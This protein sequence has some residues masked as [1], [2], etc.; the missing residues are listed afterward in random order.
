MNKI[1]NIVWS[2]TLGQWCVVSELCKSPKNRRKGI[3][4]TIITMLSFCLV[5]TSAIAANAAADKEIKEDNSQAA[6]P[7]SLVWGMRAQSSGGSIAIGSDATADA[8]IPA[9]AS[10]AIA[11]GRAAKSTGA[12]S[13]TVGSRAIASGNYGVAVG[14][15]AKAIGGYSYAAGFGANA[16]GVDSF[17]LG[18]WSQAK[19]DYSVALGKGN[20]ALGHGSV[21]IGGISTLYKTLVNNSYGIAIGAESKVYGDESIAIGRKSNINSAANKAVIVGSQ[22]SV[23][24]DSS[25]SIVIGSEAVIGD[26][27]QYAMA[28]GNSAKANGIDSIAIGHNTHV[29]VKDGIALG[30]DSKVHS[31]SVSVG[32]NNIIT[33]QDILVLGK[34][35]T[36]N[37]DNSVYLGTSS[38]AS[39]VVT[40][41]TGGSQSAVN[42]TQVDTL[43]FGQYAG[44]QA[45][46]AVTVGAVGNERRIQNVAAGLV[47]EK[48]TDAINGSQLFATQNRLSTF[49]NGTVE[50]LG[51]NASINQDGTLKKPVYSII[52]GAPA[53]GV[54]TDVHTVGDAL[55]NLNAA[56][57]SPLY[58]SSDSG[59][60]FSRKLGS[61]IKVV[62]G[63]VDE[64]LLTTNNIG[65]VSNGIDTLSIRLAQE[66][67]GLKKA[68]F[69]NGANKTVI[70]GNGLTLSNDNGK[71]ISLTD[72]EFNNGDNKI[73]HI[74]SGLDGQLLKD[75]TGD[76]LTNAANISDLKNA[77]NDVT[78]GLTNAG[79][80]LSADDGKS[81]QKALGNNITISGDKN[82]TTS[83]TKDGKLALNLN[84]DL[85]LDDGSITI[86]DTSVN[87]KGLIIAG[88]P[89][90]TNQGIDAGGKIIS[91]LADA[92]ND[93][94]AVNLGQ[95]NEKIQNVTNAS[96]WSLT[97]ES[98]TIKHEVSNQTVSVNHGLNTKVSTV[99]K[100]AL[101]N[102]SYQIDVM[103]IPMNYIDS[104]GNEL[105]NIG[106][107]F[108]TQEVNPDT[109]ETVLTKA[110]PAKVKISNDK[111]MQLTNVANGRVTSESTDAINGSQLSAAL[112][113]V[114]GSNI[115]YN[116]GKPTLKPDTFSDLST[117][118]GGDIATDGSQ[119]KQP[120]DIVAAV[121][122][123]NKE[124][125]KYFKANSNGVAAKAEGKNSTAAGAGSVAS[126]PESVAVGHN[127]VVMSSAPVGSVS[128]GSGSKAEQAHT[129]N[130]SVDN[131]IVAGKKGKDTAVVSFG[132]EGNERQLQHVAPGVLSETSTDAVNGSQLHAVSQKQSN[133]SKAIANLGNRFNQLD[134][135]VS[136]LNRDIRGV[137][138]SAAAM[139]S[140]PQAYLPGKSLMGLGVGG[141]GGESAIAIGVSTI[142][143]NGKV[144]MKLNAGNNSRGDYSVGAG[145]GFQW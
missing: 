15:S 141:Y 8:S 85:D 61:E 9:T 124:G 118:S 122:T 131:T 62:G 52:N 98:D 11:I 74:A 102:Y 38:T 121:N 12:G 103:G 136:E 115:T 10:D 73:T 3:K 114:G 30:K 144:I 7:N 26:S 143:D 50:A 133:N 60:G 126:A 116:N 54:M 83:V 18:S 67:I 132:S 28:L 19:G 105:V 64:G 100:D 45:N 46:G 55:T 75:A 119:F 58:F 24:K 94:D 13:L 101:G 140:I 138:A 89:S 86:G 53:D 49:V 97:T 65:V 44:A 81:V 32:N 56:V 22:S 59:A 130:Y 137:G 39:D 77:I 72:T 113:I 93:D 125:T 91:G 31:A 110:I 106:G 76:T 51:G 41:T 78:N 108:Y 82:I 84:K 63:N 139:S 117:A 68:E 111:P 27:S 25:G 145:V 17:A 42:N 142:S 21:A 71:I 5:S 48:S 96:T 29:L 57:G 34:N 43:V 40:D 70:D 127:S 79:F 69:V 99:T 16:V 1:F 95:L 92:I 123:I 107:E 36:G 112:D 66:L 120:V 135:K 129:G 23:G 35:V 2:P 6:D 14:H 20:E 87:N 104:K 88:G 134:N 109:G 47:S 33:G 90:V 4:K 37:V 80:G 128:I